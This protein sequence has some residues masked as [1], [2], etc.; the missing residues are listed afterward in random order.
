[1]I[2]LMPKVPAKA[3]TRTIGANDVEVKGRYPA[4]PRPYS[5]TLTQGGAC[6]GYVYVSMGLVYRVLPT[7]EGF[8]IEL[9]QAAGTT[10]EKITKTVRYHVDDEL[11]VSKL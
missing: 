3:R 9:L 7:A 4:Y 10:S 1:M 11:N 2:V 8:D 6:R 5:L